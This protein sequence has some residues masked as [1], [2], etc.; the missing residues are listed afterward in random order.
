MAP[1]AFLKLMRSLHGR[2][3][4][5]A[6]L[7]LA[8]FLGATA[9][10]LDEAFQERTESAMRERLLGHVYALLAAAD[11]DEEGRITL[12]A[13][14]PDPRFSNPSSGLYALVESRDGDFRWRSPSLT[15]QAAEFVHSQPPGRRVFS[16]ERLGDAEI[17]V[18]NFGV[19]WEDDA[20]QEQFLTFAVGSDLAPLS[21]EIEEFRYTLWLW[22]GGAA[23]V[24]LLI[25]G[26]ILRWGLQPLRTLADDLRRIE[27]GT[28]DHLAGN[29]PV[30][31]ERLTADLN[32][33][34]A[35]SRANQQRYRNALDDLAHSLKTPLAILRTATDPTAP[36]S[37]LRTQVVEQVGQMDAIVQHQLRR[38]AA[39]GRVTLGQMTEVAP[40]VE[41]LIRALRKV[42]RDRPLDIA[43]DA[44]A[45]ARFFGDRADLMEILGNLLDNACKY[46]HGRVRLSARTLAGTG[47]RP[48]LVLRIEDD[49]PGIAPAAVERALERGQRLDSSQPGQGLGL[50]M[51]REIVAV[52]G[53]GLTIDR[54]ELG[55]ARIE[56]R[57]EPA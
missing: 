41:Q 31:L 53:G 2:L 28:L 37:E 15:G 46:A 54:G 25:Q 16:R 8:A 44:S 6:T 26:L 42:Y 33:L 49:G 34:I 32:A 38:A 52:Y 13:D 5:A 48:G 22:L 11:D 40:V 50:A 18:L 29:Y 1:T 21:S 39:A 35:N 45:D 56:V 17:H 36:S 4:V 57:F 3:L 14:L 24:L 43:S 23:V 20:G 47:A 19:A 55:G 51:V 7:V 27:A 12:P 9:L 10:A 30:E